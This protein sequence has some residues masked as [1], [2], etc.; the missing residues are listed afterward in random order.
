MFLN[1]ILTVLTI[2]LISIT[3]LLN[4]WWRKYGKKLFET[5][6]SVKSLTS[7]IPIQTLQGQQSPGNQNPGQ[8]IGDLMDRLKK[9]NQMFGSMKK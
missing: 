1:I 4:I 3:V 2:V 8:N 5:L 9:L 6:S 7:Q